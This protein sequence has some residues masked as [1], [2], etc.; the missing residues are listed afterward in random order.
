MGCACACLF[1]QFQFSLSLAMG[2]EVFL[3]RSISLFHG[4]SSFVI[5]ISHYMSISKILE[6]GANSLDTL[7]SCQNY[8]ASKP[9]P[10]PLTIWDQIL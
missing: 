5:T 10:K 4:W 3:S 8:L 6:T 1:L 2:K 7:V 9:F